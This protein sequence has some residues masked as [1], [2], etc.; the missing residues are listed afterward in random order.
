MCCVTIIFMK[1]KILSI[2]LVISSLNAS[3]A[4]K[5]SCGYL[6]DNCIDGRKRV[7]SEEEL[8][9][10]A[11][12]CNSFLKYTEFRASKKT[13][14]IDIIGQ[15][16]SSKNLEDGFLFKLPEKGDYRIYNFLERTFITISNSDF[17][18]GTYGNLYLLDMSKKNVKKMMALPF[19]EGFSL[20]VKNNILIYSDKFLCEKG[21][22]KTFNIKQDLFLS[23]K[24]SCP[25]KFNNLRA[26]KNLAKNYFKKDT[27][28]DVLKDGYI[29]FSD[30]DCDV[31]K[32]NNSHIKWTK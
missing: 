4:R 6:D 1:I 31:I 21:S 12:Y 7:I 30:I 17:L 19:N 2:F 9:K 10:N 14:Y 13:Y 28:G 18:Q 26:A 3:A 5:Y 25:Q 16:F 20:E 27:N 22:S 15:I 11:V 23:S 32:K 24:I 8:E 29:K